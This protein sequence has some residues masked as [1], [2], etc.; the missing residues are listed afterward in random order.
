M[1]KIT[2]LI[3]FFTSAIFAAD[4]PLET[5]LTQGGTTIVLRVMNPDLS[6][7]F[8]APKHL[9]IIYLSIAPGTSLAQ[10]TARYVC[11][12]GSVRESHVSWYGFG[13]PGPNAQSV[14]LYGCASA[15]VRIL[16]VKITAFAKMSETELKGE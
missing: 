16:S 12:G 3:L 6:A 9:T 1:R 10:V 15:D 14:E 13:F 7:P 8:D 5:L 2:S 4:V 11:G